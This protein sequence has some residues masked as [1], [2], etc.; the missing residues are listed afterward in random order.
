MSF[1][2]KEFLNLA[3]FLKGDSKIKY[4]SEAACR[5]V[6]G[7]AYF[8]AFCSSRNFARDNQGYKPSYDDEDHKNIRKHYRMVRMYK[9]AKFLDHLRIWRNMCD[10]DDVITDAEARNTNILANTAIERAQKVLAEL[11]KS[12]D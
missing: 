3:L 12:T 8:T 7:R 6:V 10:Y 5:T 4:S 9:I 1:D 11:S 2:W